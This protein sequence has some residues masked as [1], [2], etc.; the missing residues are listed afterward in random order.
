MVVGVLQGSPDRCGSTAQMGLTKRGT[1]H[2]SY[3]RMTAL[4]ALN[5][6]A[7]TRERLDEKGATRLSDAEMVAVVLGTGHRGHNVIEVASAALARFGGL[8]QLAEASEPDLCTL[9]GFGPVRAAIVNASLE[10]GRR[11]AGARPERGRRL[12]YASDVWSHY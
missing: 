6:D 10:L 2:A 8:R 12:G 3:R 9:P 11:L 4:L 1:T 5:P 7:R